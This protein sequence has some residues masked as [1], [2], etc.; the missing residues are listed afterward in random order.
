VPD[1]L[2]A[3][4]HPP[5]DDGDGYDPEAE[6][7]SFDAARM[8]RAQAAALMSLDRVHVGPAT[9]PSAPFR[10]LRG[11][12]WLTVHVGEQEARLRAIWNRPLR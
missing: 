6:E 10:E 1:V 5:A 4:G 3:P 11:G 8:K 9:K 12:P 2:K 7:L